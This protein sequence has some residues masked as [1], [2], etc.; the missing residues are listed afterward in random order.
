VKMCTW[1][2]KASRHACTTTEAWRPRQ[3]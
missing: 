1:M 3:L 2:W